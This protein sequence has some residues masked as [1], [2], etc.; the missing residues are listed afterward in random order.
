[1][2][3]M[4]QIEGMMCQHCRKHVEEALQAVPGVTAVTVDLAGH[5]AKVVSSAAVAPETLI[6][7]VRKA[8]YEARSL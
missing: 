4:L 3:Q 7:A 1:M 8:G 6:E 2:E 5:S